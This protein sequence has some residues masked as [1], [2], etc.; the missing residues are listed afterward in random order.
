[1]RTKNPKKA[2]AILEYVDTFF[3]EN[4]RTP[5][6]REIEAGTGISRPMVQRYLV[7]MDEK[8]V[9]KYKGSNIITEFIEQLTSQNTVRLPISGAIPCGE[10]QTENE[11]NDCFIE[12]PTSLLGKGEYFVLLADGESM[13]DAGIDDGDFVIVRKT[14]T[15][16]YGTIIVALDSDNRNTLKRLEFD[17][18]KKRPYLQPE[19]KKYKDIYPAELSIQG[20]AEK[21]IKNLI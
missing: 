6:I 5:S 18:E 8:G 9:I 3:E 13:T 20:V 4:L 16:D 12:F 17:N 15:A 7:D 11:L 2:K 19:N 21:V 1:M 10:P 14:N